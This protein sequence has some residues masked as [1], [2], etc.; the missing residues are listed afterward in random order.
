VVIWQFFCRICYFSADKIIK[1]YAEIWNVQEQLQTYRPIKSRH[2]RNARLGTILFSYLYIY[3]LYRQGHRKQHYLTEKW[4]HTA[5]TGGTCV[6]PKRDL[7][8]FSGYRYTMFVDVDTASVR[9]LNRQLAE[10]IQLLDREIERNSPKQPPSRHRN[11]IDSPSYRRRRWRWLPI[12]SS[13][14]QTDA[15]HLCD[16]CSPG[17]VQ[18]FTPV[19]TKCLII[20]ST[21][22]KIVDILL[23]FLRCTEMLR[24]TV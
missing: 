17:I 19:S 7:S 5:C 4:E 23:T 20:D 2:A 18:L 3:L 9:K 1:A 11:S 24:Q 12:T 10:D 15:A 16:L 6:K 21:P 13:Y 22:S 8:H 14:L